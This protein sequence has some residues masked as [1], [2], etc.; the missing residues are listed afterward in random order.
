M[1]LSVL[2]H[3]AAYSASANVWSPPDGV[4]MVWWM[5]YQIFAPLFLLQLLN[6]FWYFLIWRVAYRYVCLPCEVSDTCLTSVC[7]ALAG[8]G[9]DDDRSDDE[10]DADGDKED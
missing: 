7:R 2:A 6:L 8:Q 10:G 3:F 5:R 1:H 4:W 9:I